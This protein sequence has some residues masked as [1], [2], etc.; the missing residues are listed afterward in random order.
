MSSATVR[1]SVFLACWATVWLAGAAVAEQ[2]RPAP[3]APQPAPVDAV[4]NDYLLMASLSMRPNTR[5]PQ[6]R[7]IIEKQLASLREKYRV[8]PESRRA[9]ILAP[10]DGA[11]VAQEDVFAF[12]AGD[13]LDP[14]AAVYD[15]RGLLPVI[16]L[17]GTYGVSLVDGVYATQIPN[18]T[19]ARRDGVVFT[20]GGGRWTAGAAD[21][22]AAGRK[23]PASASRTIV[24]EPVVRSGS[25]SLSLRS[26]VVSPGDACSE[27]A[28]RVTVQRTASGLAYFFPSGELVAEFLEVTYIPDGLTAEDGVVRLVLLD[29]GR[30]EMTTVPALRCEAPNRMSW[31]FTERP[32]GRFFVRVKATPP[33]DDIPLEI[34]AVP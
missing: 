16:E 27:F 14:V 3:Q 22:A 19:M 15:D 5:D 30:N 13:W 33:L 12:S 10:P 17:K 25:A 6:R 8:K 18:G 20:F 31:G 4:V 9:T 7:S 24:H 23:A 29:A 34:K 32:S 2:R 26:R 28:S 21:A 11:I 1:S